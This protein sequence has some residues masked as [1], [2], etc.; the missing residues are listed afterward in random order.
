M[1]RPKKDNKALNIKL[2]AKL[3]EELE[4]YCDKTKRTKTSVIELALEEYL[5]NNN[6]HD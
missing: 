1:A 4:R 5:K 2:D 6:K 3:Y